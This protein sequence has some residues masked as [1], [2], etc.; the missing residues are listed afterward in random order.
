MSKYAPLAEYLRLQSANE[1]RLDFVRIE[2]IIEGPL[3]A[4]A[5]NHREWWANDRSGHHAWATEWMD[6][7][8]MCDTVSL[9]EQ[10]VRFR[11]GA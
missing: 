3:P 4:S 2:T 6:A 10:W 9:S 7:G 5:H 1:V 8:W 11:R